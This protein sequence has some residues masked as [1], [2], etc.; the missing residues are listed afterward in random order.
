MKE[1]INKRVDLERLKD[2]DL[3]VLDMD[4]TI[5]LGDIVLEGSREFIKYAKD[6]GKKIIYF[7]NNAS[8]NK[9]LYYE[10]LIRLG[11][12]ADRSE[13]MTSGD[14]TIAY[15]KKYHPGESVYLVGTPELENAFKRAEIE[16]TDGS[17][18]DIVITS[19]D[20]TLTYDKLVKACDLLRAGKIYYS[21]H[22]DI[23][24]PVLEYDKS[25]S[26]ITSS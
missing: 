12:E 25:I 14:V 5:Y 23:N 21:T 20:T 26:L 3:F 7:T 24:C 13:I 11:Y 19:F 9:E 4:G 10:K 2:I 17:D 16:L 18:A 1:I 22:E 15:L 8:K 6:N